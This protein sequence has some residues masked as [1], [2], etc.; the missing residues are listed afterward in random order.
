MQFASCEHP[1]VIRSAKDGSPIYVPCG[2]C[3]IC[4]VRRQINWVERLEVERMC[5]PYCVFFTLTYTESAVPRLHLVDG[6]YYDSDGAFCFNPYKELN[7]SLSDMYYIEHRCDLPICSVYDIQIFLKRLRSQIYAHETE[8]KNKYLRYFVCSEYGPTT[9]RPHYH[10][11][12][13]FSSSWFAANASEVISC[14]WT[15]DFRI[16][17]PKSKG[18]VDV[19]FVESSASSYVA[20]Y[21]NCFDNLPE[22]YRHKSIRPFFLCSRHPPI[23]SLLVKSAEIQQLF[24]TQSAEMCVYRRTVG[25]YCYVPLP[26]SLK[27][28]LYP[29]VAD[30]DKI[31]HSLR[32]K[33]YGLLNSTL[34]ER[35]F[36]SRCSY[37][38][39][40]RDLNGFAGDFDFMLFKQF[41]DYLLNDVHDISETELHDYL[42]LLLNYR[43]DVNN[44]KWLSEKY[45][46]D[47]EK[48][49]DDSP[50]GALHRFYTVIKRVSLQSVSFGVSIEEYVKRIERFYSNLDAL[51]LRNQYDFEKEYCQLNS[52]KDLLFID[53]LTAEKLIVRAKDYSLSQQDIMILNSYG[54]S[55]Y[56]LIDIDNITSLSIEDLSAYKD[57]KSKYNKIYN[58]SCKTRKKNEY[59]EI[60]KSDSLIK[61]LDAY[62]KQKHF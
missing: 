60:R 45:G 59:L 20:S 28:R 49:L 53:R 9:F 32:V 18:K 3:H 41:L 15:D 52:A 57:I 26:G 50:D 16:K 27:D 24:D 42:Y 30:F 34:A 35:F 43:N 25:E 7:L 22:V 44:K 19:Q 48:R 37:K 17:C 21:V 5:H 23:G 2:K 58:E 46:D 13:F 1:V 40:D 55:D 31:P 61:V 10:G 39:N 56:D 6:C 4:K 38:G 47:W 33:L 12:L 36:F 11:I 62:G 51:M 29:K 14:S 54:Y 8:S